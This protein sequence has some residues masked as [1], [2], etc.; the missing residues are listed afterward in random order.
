MILTW[1]VLIPIIGGVLAWLAVAFRPALA[2]WIALATCALDL[3]LGLKL[4]LGLSEDW[5]VNAFYLEQVAPWIPRLGI[6]YHLA[7]DGVSLLLALLTAFLGLVAVACSWREI[8]S[9]VGAYHFSLLAVLT[10]VT[11]V[12]LAQDLL[13]FYFFWELMLVPMYFL[14]GVW[15]HERRIYAAIKF[16]LFTFISSLL[17]LAAILA[18]VFLHAGATGVTTFDARTLM[19]T[20]LTAAA[21]MW[22]MLGFFVAFAVKLPAVPLHTWLVDAHTEAPTGGSVLLAGLLLKTG[23]YGML[24]LAIPLFPQTLASFTPAA[25]ILGVVGILYGA[26][27][28]FAQ[29]DFKRMVAYSSISHMGFVLLGIYVGSQVALQGAMIQIIA[30]GLGTGA[31]FVLS[32]SILER[33]GTR[34]LDR[35]GGLWSTAPRLG[36]FVA[37]FAMA[38]L[39][40]PGLANFL[41]E[42]LVLLGAYQV[43]VTLAAVGSVGLVLSTV[44]A[45]R[46]VQESVHGPNREGWRVPDLSARELVTLGVMAAIL[47]WLGFLPRPVLQAARAALA[48]PQH[49][50][51]EF[52]EAAV[53]AGARPAVRSDLAPGDA[54]QSDQ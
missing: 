35:L 40:L 36:G 50:P 29:T 7:L 18:L 47:V 43:S 14:I 27:L 39:G 54:E 6:S 32:G 13:L 15:G 28:A 2:R 48:S 1:L 49:Q 9:H 41:G 16:F 5:L 19:A 8:T 24:R 22:I 44:Y 34:N 17:M 25:L 21:A 3:A 23:A 12:F 51:A 26:M 53:S 33:C 4:Y 42:F 30:H 10:G 45:L 38:A 52:A 11:G 20:P 46:L 31:L 37:F